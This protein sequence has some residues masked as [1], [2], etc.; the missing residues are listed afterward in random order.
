MMVMTIR[1]CHDDFIQKVKSGLEL[2]D[3]VVTDVKF[4]SAL[5]VSAC[6]LWIR[7]L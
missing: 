1:G 2:V 5:V 3:E 4:Y 6:M 7:W